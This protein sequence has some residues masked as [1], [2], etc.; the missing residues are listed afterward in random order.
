MICTGSGLDALSC[1]RTFAV[2]PNL[3]HTDPPGYTERRVLIKSE[4]YSSCSVCL[5][6]E[7]QCGCRCTVTFQLVFLPIT[8]TVALVSVSSTHHTHLTLTREIIWVFFV[9][10]YKLLYSICKQ[11]RFPSNNH[12]IK[13]MLRYQLQSLCI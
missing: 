7:I 10:Q 11:F 3:K 1:V 9:V 13:K 5:M 12:Q 8:V 2:L 6:S 4:S